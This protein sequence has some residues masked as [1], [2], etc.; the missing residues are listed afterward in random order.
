MLLITAS[1]AQLIANRFDVSCTIRYKLVTNMR[2]NKR[3]E[4]SKK[5]ILEK[6]SLIL[7]IFSP[8]LHTCWIKCIFAE[9]TR[10]SP[11]RRQRYLLRSRNH[12]L[13]SNVHRNTH[14]V[15]IEDA[16]SDSGTRFRFAPGYASNFRRCGWRTHSKEENADDKIR[17]RVCE[18]LDC[19]FRLC[20]LD[21]W[22]F[23]VKIR[24]K[25]NSN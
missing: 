13:R 24:D 5:K 15:K 6:D 8:V 23:E 1:R 9:Y 22:V 14:H 19:E 11:I 18:D 2:P 17:D 21:S 10:R 3:L 16:M 7:F 12:C 25:E 20:L 4:L